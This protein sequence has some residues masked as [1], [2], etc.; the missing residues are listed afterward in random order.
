[1][2][3]PPIVQICTFSYGGSERHPANMRISSERNSC[4]IWGIGLRS[5]WVAQLSNCT[6]NDM[7]TTM[8]VAVRYIAGFV[9]VDSAVGP[10]R[11]IGP[12]PL[13]Q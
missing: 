8:S 1:M 12:A 11:A 5:K 2:R 10:A 6:A 4:E 13:A 9:T 7:V 3:T